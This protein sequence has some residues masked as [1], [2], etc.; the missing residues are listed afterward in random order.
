MLD[1]E[2]VEAKR[3]VIGLIGLII[4][5][6]VTAAGIAL[7]YHSGQA[8]QQQ[9]S[10][11]S[12]VEVA[13]NAMFSASDRIETLAETS[14][15]A[16]RELSLPR[17]S[18]SSAQTV[19]GGSIEVVVNDDPAC[20]ASAELDAIRYTV[21][22]GG[23]FDYQAGGIWRVGENG[24]ATRITNPGVSFRDGVLRVEAIDFATGDSATGSL[25]L[26]NRQRASEKATL[27]ARESLFSQPGCNTPEN[28][29]VRVTSQKFAK[30]WHEYFQE[31]MPGTAQ[32]SYSP[33]SHAASVRFDGND[34]PA[35][36]DDDRNHVVDFTSNNNLGRVVD[37]DSDGNMELVVDK[38]VG[39]TYESTVSLVGTQIGYTKTLYETVTNSTPDDPGNNATDEGL[40]V[41]LVLDLSASMN[42]SMLADTTN[43][44]EEFIDNLDAND[45]I[46]VAAYARHNALIQPITS[47]HSAAVQAVQNLSNDT[48]GA[49]TYLS[50]AIERTVDHFVWGANVRPDKRNVG[51]LISDGENDQ[52][53]GSFHQARQ[54]ALNKNVR[55]HTVGFG[56]DYRDSVVDTNLASLA[57]YT[58]GTFYDEPSSDDLEHAL[59]DI[60]NEIDPVPGNSSTQQKV[61]ER[62]IVHNPTRLQLSVGGDTYQPWAGAAPPASSHINYPM[63]GA[64]PNWIAVDDGDVVDFDQI[65]IWTCTDNST[66]GEVETHPS[67]SEQYKHA[68]CT[69]TGYSVTSQNVELFV[70]GDSIPAGTPAFWQEPLPESIPSAYV[71]DTDSDPQPDEFDLDP[72][73]A[74]AVFELNDNGH[75]DKNNVVVLYEV[76]ENRSEASGRWVIDFQVEKFEIEDE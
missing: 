56:P 75:P 59:E 18:V 73:Q 35:V 6:G 23:S 14:G 22:D 53:L 34:L 9:I 47:N 60:L 58:G 76:G 10:H 28:V 65:Q 51:V 24:A 70:D 33:G 25:T 41:I 36:V 39:N 62:L 17:E 43:A 30:R 48:L 13:E 29:T 68:R 31:S 42:D 1:G 32:V 46:G 45:R 55:F 21:P 12:N 40:G 72:N 26:E 3:G 71:A 74:I 4:L 49:D 19:D 63:G 38:G 8:A 37:A 44:A 15:D 64:S 52:S 5:V 67:T 61:R 57:S 20:S 2:T 11:Q 66:T 27:S 69:A 16:Q 50:D 7:I 54:K